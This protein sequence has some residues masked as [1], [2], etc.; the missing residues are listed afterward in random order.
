VSSVI[1]GDKINKVRY[2]VKLTEKEL[3]SMPLVTQ[4]ETQERRRIFVKSLTEGKRPGAA[5]KLAGYAHP[6]VDAWRLM[7]HPEVI[8]ALRYAMDARAVGAMPQA[9]ETLIDLQNVKYPPSV[10]LAAAKTVIEQD[11][12]LR[13]PLEGAALDGK[14]LDKMTEAELLDVAR[15]LQEQRQTLEDNAPIE[16]PNDGQVID[17]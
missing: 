13:R 17:M 5:A 7:Q 9:I 4:K 16:R 1:G 6:S 15:K 11:R 14:T 10:R 12:A 2:F 8:Q 3:I